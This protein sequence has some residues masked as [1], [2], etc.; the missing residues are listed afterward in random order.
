MPFLWKHKT[1]KRWILFV[2][3][4]KIPDCVI[5]NEI[6]LIFSL[7][8]ITCLNC[9]PPMIQFMIY[10]IT[11][12]FTMIFKQTHHKLFKLANYNFITRIL[13]VNAVFILLL[14]SG[15]SHSLYLVF[16]SWVQLQVTT[17]AICLK[18]NKLVS[19]RDFRTSA[20]KGRIS[21][22]TWVK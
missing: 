10:G 20:L 7:T 2:F 17:K 22:K 21:L 4:L 6:R 5:S 19:W 8:Q 9:L 12:W 16:F 13:D 18:T 14:R 1:V 11:I 15:R 3:K